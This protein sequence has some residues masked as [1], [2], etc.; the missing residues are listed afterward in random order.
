MEIIFFPFSNGGNAAV[1]IKSE[2]H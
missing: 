2:Y 1:L